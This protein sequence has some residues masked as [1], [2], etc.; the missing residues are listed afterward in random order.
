[1]R[2]LVPCWAPKIGRPRILNYFMANIE[3]TGQLRKTRSAALGTIAQSNRNN[4][5]F[6]GNKSLGKRTNDT[7]AGALF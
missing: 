5:R 4:L 7:L 6:Q 2:A 3:G 1:M